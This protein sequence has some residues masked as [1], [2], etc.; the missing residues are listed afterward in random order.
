MARGVKF[1]MPIEKNVKTGEPETEKIDI[2]ELDGKVCCEPP[3]SEAEFEP[4]SL[5]NSPERDVDKQPWI[6]GLNRASRNASTTMDLGRPHVF[7][8]KSCSLLCGTPSLSCLETHGQT[9]SPAL[10]LGAKQGCLDASNKLADETA[11]DMTVG[12]IDAVPAPHALLTPSADAEKEVL[13]GQVCDNYADR[14]EVKPTGAS[15]SREDVEVGQKKLGAAQSQI[16]EPDIGAG[17]KP[18]TE[19]SGNSPIPPPERISAPPFDKPFD[20]IFGADVVYELSHATLVHDVVQRLLRK[21]SYDPQLP[22]AYFHLIMPLRPTHADEATSVDQTFP[23]VEDVHAQRD[24]EDEVLAI[25][26]TETYARSAGI[27]R[28]D[29][30]QYVYYRMAWV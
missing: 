2:G 27:G 24:G 4:S 15:W 25:V 14:I 20:I 8:T 1:D 29:E 17:C 10:H 23:R 3:E 22:P 5:P 13:F 9:T 19:R 26:R 18:A 7:S 11:S 12:T 16:R 30:V 21:P 28:A 6:D